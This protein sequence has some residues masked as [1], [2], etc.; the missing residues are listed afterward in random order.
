MSRRTASAS[1]RAVALIDPYAR[2][3]SAALPLRSRIIDPDFDWQRRPAAGDAVARY[4]D[5]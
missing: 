1:I 2:R 3:L 4:R 5:L